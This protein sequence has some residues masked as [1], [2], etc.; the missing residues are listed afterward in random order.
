M[1]KVRPV[2]KVK[3]ERLP[4]EDNVLPF[5]PAVEGVP[6]GARDE[7]GGGTILMGTLVKISADGNVWVQLE[8][9][10][11]LAAGCCLSATALVSLTDRDVGATLALLRSRDA[12]AVVL[13]KR[14]PARIEERAKP[15]IEALVDGRRVVL[16]ADDE[17]VLRCGDASITLNRNGRIVLKGAY[18]ETTATGIN[19]IKGGAVQI[20]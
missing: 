14:H 1:A 19:R 18:V 4:R 16:Q 11:D 6:G 20:N 5:K 17:V 12:Q 3:R 8:T 7:S 15:P 13:G 9:G 10:G 2:N